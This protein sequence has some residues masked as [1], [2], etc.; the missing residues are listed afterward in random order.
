MIIRCPNCGAVLTYDP[1]A[2]QMSCESCCSF[3]DLNHFHVSKEDVVDEITL[4]KEDNKDGEDTFES[5][6]YHCTSCGARLLVNQVEA[7]TFCAYC[8][9]P[10]ICFERI[11]RQKRPDK[12]I[13]FMI[14]KKQAQHIVEERL[15]EGSFVPLGIKNTKADQI[16]GIYIPFT[17]FD[18]FY[19][20]KDIYRGVVRETRNSTKVL[21]FFRKGASEF[22]NLTVDS[23]VQLNDN[24]SRRLEPYYVKGLK[25]F[26]PN[27]LSG[28]Y[29]DCGDEDKISLRHTAKVRAKNMYD[30]EMRKTVR[31]SN[32]EHIQSIPH[33]DILREETALLPAWFF[34]Y[35]HEGKRYTLMVNGQ[36]GK[37]VG[38]VPMDK[39]KL[40]IMSVAITLT[41]CILCG[42]IASKLPLIPLNIIF[43]GILILVGMIVFTIQKKK[44]KYKIGIALTTAEKLHDFSFDRSD[45]H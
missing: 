26:N 21:Y 1:I 5:E 41:I 23:S 13:P 3:F 19:E 45:T 24:S 27:Y 34:V 31:A 39:K 6:I 33:A 22:K 32:V 40:T 36:T 20:S 7:A 43:P 28:Y 9:Q 30:K 25:E 29:A 17:I 16:R 38:T 10:T 8:N 18:L 11:G 44:E 37:V 2:N 14:S 35:N 42:G 15:R 12:I 4:E